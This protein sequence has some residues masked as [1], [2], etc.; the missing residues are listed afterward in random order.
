MKKPLYLFVLVGAVSLAGFVSVSGNGVPEGVS[1]FEAGGRTCVVFP[2]GSG[3]CFCECENSCSPD[4]VV[5]AG[6]PVIPATNTPVVATS[7]P[8]PEVTPEVTKQACG[9][10]KDHDCGHGNDGDRSDNDNP[11]GGPSQGKPGSG[12]DEEQ[13]G[14]KGGRHDK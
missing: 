1:V 14:T 3:E 2:D 6:T 7:T 9:Q 8:V 5:F 10:N 12:R 11:N 4:V 13:G